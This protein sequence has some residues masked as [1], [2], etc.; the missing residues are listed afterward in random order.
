MA[1]SPEGYPEL[2]VAAERAKLEGALEPLRERGVVEIVWLDQATLSALH[3]RISDPDHVHVLH[4]IG[5]GAYDEAKNDGVLIFEDSRGRPRPISGEELCTI[6]RDEQSLRLVVLNSCEGARS[7]RRDPFSSVA[8][9]LVACQ[10]PAVIGMQVEITDDAAVTFAESLYAAITHGDAIDAAV[11][12]TRKALFAEEHDTEFGTPVL[13]LRSGDARLFDITPAV[14]KFADSHHDAPAELALTLK[15]QP[16]PAAAGD[17]VTW[18][19]TIRNRGQQA[20][21]AIE[22]T[23]GRGR[24]LASAPDLA[25]GR[26]H[27]IGWSQPARPDTSVNVTVTASEPNGSRVSE[28]ISHAVNVLHVA[29]DEPPQPPPAP[30]SAPADDLPAETT[31]AAVEPEAPAAP[32]PPK[33]KTRP[34]RTTASD[35]ATPPQSANAQQLIAKITARASASSDTVRFRLD[36]HNATDGG[37]SDVLVTRPVDRQDREIVRIA[38]LSPGHQHPTVLDRARADHRMVAEARDDPCALA[39]RREFVIGRRC[40]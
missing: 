31:P 1:S 34:P 27:R 35:S 11:A 25:P 24:T 33:R 36:V 37:L 2:D 39:D 10:V 23:E 29:K 21:S 16:D 40:G 14:G 7:S 18:S 20:L 26:R 15:Q 30:E 8:A 28:H 19:L 38:H 5:H 22:V 17:I 9:G 13:F 3:R 32:E 4:F 6:L 12:Q